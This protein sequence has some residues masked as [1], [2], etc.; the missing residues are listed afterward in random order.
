MLSKIRQIGQYK[1]PVELQ[2][3]T[4]S[5]DEFGGITEEWKKFKTL[6]VKFDSLSGRAYFDA[7][8]AQSEVTGTMKSRFVPGV[9]EKKDKLRIKYNG[10]II[11]IKEVFDP[12]ET[13][14]ELEF[15]IKDRARDD[16]NGENEG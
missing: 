3:L 10:R 8:Q 14:Q 9:I 4:E 11:E 13:K 16:D 1:T 15:M 12:D 5:K 7:K 6:W 2:E